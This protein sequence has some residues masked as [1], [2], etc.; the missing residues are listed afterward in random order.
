MER[1]KKKKARE[2]E[3]VN[4]SHDNKA[5]RQQKKIVMMTG[6]KLYL[7]YLLP[8]PQFSLKYACLLAFF[9]SKKCRYLYSYN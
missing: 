7:H 8:M 3:T 5:L 1:V 6:D 4:E 9:L 2:T